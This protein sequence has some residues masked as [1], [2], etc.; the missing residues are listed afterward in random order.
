MV[1]DR[2]GIPNLC[3]PPG[4]FLAGALAFF[5]C[6]FCEKA[7]FDPTYMKPRIIAGSSAR[8][9]LA[10]LSPVFVELGNQD[11]RVTETFGLT[12]LGKGQS[13]LANV[14]KVNERTLS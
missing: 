11:V 4:V 6:P 2:L 12:V 3:A 5:T 1:G 9:G 10:E 13:R 8:N 14:R 7:L